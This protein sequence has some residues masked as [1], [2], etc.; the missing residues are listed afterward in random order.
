MHTKQEKETDERIA[1][2]VT[3]LSLLALRCLG[4]PGYACVSDKMHTIMH[5]AQTFIETKRAKIMA[6]LLI[7]H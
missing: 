1:F 4:L 2:L 6:L 5:T 7:F 3:N